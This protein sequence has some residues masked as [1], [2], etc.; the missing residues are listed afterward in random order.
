[1]HGE[2]NGGL[3]KL[4]VLVEVLI[5]DYM[6]SHKMVAMRKPYKKPPRKG[7]HKGCWRW[8]NREGESLSRKERPSLWRPITT[9]TPD[10]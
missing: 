4:N 9:C 2:W 5:D 10:S 6:G 3:P 7:M 8:V 1:M